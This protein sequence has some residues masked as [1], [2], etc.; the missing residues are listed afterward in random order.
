MAESNKI[1]CDRLYGEGRAVI[2]GTA[3]HANLKGKQNVDVSEFVAVSEEIVIDPVALATHFDDELAESL[4]D[5]RMT[6]EQLET[7]LTA[8]T[9]RRVWDGAVRDGHDLEAHPGWA[10]CG[11]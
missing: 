9:V 4:S 1:L 7:P 8:G 2:G 6:R 3:M 10:G 5:H 11:V